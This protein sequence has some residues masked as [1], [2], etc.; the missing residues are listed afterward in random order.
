MTARTQTLATCGAP[1]PAP[2]NVWVSHVGGLLDRDRNLTWPPGWPAPRVGD[3][4]TVPGG[5]PMYVR[6]VV[7]YPEGN[8]D[9]AEPFV[10]VVVGSSRP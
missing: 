4:F 8:E 7:W 9:D 3:E 5:P 1:I 10:Y 6:T 2:L